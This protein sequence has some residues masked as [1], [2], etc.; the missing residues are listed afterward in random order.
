MPGGESLVE[1]QARVEAAVAPLFAEPASGARCEH[2][3]VVVVSHVGPIKAAVAWALGAGPGL[4]LRLRLDNGSIT[5]IA[6]GIAAPVLVSYNVV[7]P[8]ARGAATS[9]R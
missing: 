1:L 7:P 3:D 9:P 5:T 8:A 6:W 4:A 2:G